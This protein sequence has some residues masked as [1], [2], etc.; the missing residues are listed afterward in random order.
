MCERGSGKILIC[1]QVCKIPEIFKIEKRVE[2]EKNSNLGER[3]QYPSKTSTMGKKQLLQYPVLNSIFFIKASSQG[4]DDSNKT[5]S[6][7]H[8]R[9]DAHMN[10]QRL[11][12]GT[13]PT[14]D[15]AWG[16]KVNMV[17]ICNQ[18]VIYNWYPFVE[19]KL[20][21]FNRVSLEQT[22]NNNKKCLSDSGQHT[23]CCNIETFNQ[24]VTW[25]AQSFLSVKFAL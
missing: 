13:G 14:L 11:A 6:S 1:E 18:E 12:A 21:F 24:Y 23:I 22:T 5:V 15:Q 4:S 2:N 19:E 10:S 16:R 20:V 8:N 17:S 25:E 7:R 3:C 9:T